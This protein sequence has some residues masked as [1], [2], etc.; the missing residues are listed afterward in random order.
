[1]GLCIDVVCLFACDLDL[2]CVLVLRPCFASLFFSIFYVKMLLRSINDD[3][4]ERYAHMRKMF[5]R[6][7][8]AVGRLLWIPKCV[9]C[10]KILDEDTALCPACE[11]A[12]FE[13]KDVACA[14]CGDH[15]DRCLCTSPTLQN[16][17]IH[18]LVKC[19]RYDPSG[20]ASVI[21]RLIYHA[22]RYPHKRLFA[23]MASEMAGS[24]FPN[25]QHNLND[26]TITWVPRGHKNLLNHGFDHAQK[27]AKILAKTWHIKAVR[28]VWR[29]YHG[30][31]QKHLN[32]WERKENAKLSF[33]PPR[34]D[35]QGKRFI[36]IDDIATTG[37]SLGRCA[38][39]LRR[40]GAKEVVLL[41]F[42][43]T[44][45]PDTCHAK[46]YASRKKYR[47]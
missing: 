5:S 35:C 4:E 34:F 26:Y 24:A 22:K 18:R 28:T 9:A 31:A 38:R 25:L 17:N 13:A 2:F 30:L 41:T 37:A 19:V 15:F 47:F 32:R 36:L 7:F 1:M 46:K 14:I 21:N 6:F 10:H 39:L 42:A 27:L 33:L 45:I 12:Y 43:K 29:H 40:A 44:N 8:K 11:K 20:K 3:S 23:F 16:N